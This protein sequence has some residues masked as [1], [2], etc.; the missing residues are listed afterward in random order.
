M[1]SPFLVSFAVLLGVGT[2]CAVAAQAPVQI[3][4]TGRVDSRIPIAVPPFVAGRGAENYGKNLAAVLSRDLDFTGVFTIVERN[5]YPPNFR[6]LQ[7]DASKLDFAAWRRTPAE[8]LIHAALRTEGDMVVAECR[9]FDIPVAQQVVGKR[10]RTRSQW[11]RLL[12]HQFADETVRFLTGVAGVAS[13]E[14]TFSGGRQR[15]VKEIYIADYD[16][17]KVTQVTHHGSISIKPKFSPD[18]NKIAYLSYKDR[19]PWLYVYDRRTGASTSL[20]KRPGLNHAPAWSPDGR[21]I[22]LVLS[23]DANTEIYLKNADGSGEQRLTNHRASDTS[24]AFSPDG[25]RLVFVSD[26]GG[27]AQL[28]VM[29]VDGSGVRRLSFQ[30]G[31]SYDPAWSPDGRHIAYIVEKDGLGLEL[32]MMNPDGTGA[33]PLTRSMG[34]NES[35]S[36]SPDSRHIAFGSSRAGLSQLYTVTVETGVV[37]QIP[38][39]TDLHSEGPSWGPRRN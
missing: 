3:E 39:L 28:Y 4:S 8:H 33:R 32:W 6:G 22:A 27:R 7:L 15:G 36:W 37:R 26:R 38:N 16:G 30:G 21:H 18:G 19:Y 24:P 2:T 35:P 5:D 34:S 11:A 14:I 12:A 9:L 1:R 31:S 13:S 10:L 20:S 23:K 29:R 25:H 17:G